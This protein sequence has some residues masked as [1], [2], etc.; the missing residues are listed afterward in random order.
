MKRRVLFLGIGI[1]WMMTL[2]GI[3]LYP[4]DYRVVSSQFHAVNPEEKPGAP[5]G[6]GPNELIVY[7]PDYGQRTGTNMWGVEAI[8]RNGII[9]HI[10]GNNSPI[11]DD[12]KVISGHGQSR[13]WILDGL[14]I[15]MEVEV[16]YDEK[17]ITGS[18]TDRS[19][20]YLLEKEYDLYDERSY[21]ALFHHS[22]QLER[23]LE[24]VRERLDSLHSQVTEEEVFNIRLYRRIKSDLEWIYWEQFPYLEE[25]RGLFLSASLVINHSEDILKFADKHSFRALYI[26]LIEDKGSVIRNNALYPDAPYS[27]SLDEW[28]EIL[29]ILNENDID[30]YFVFSPLKL[31]PS[32]ER[33]IQ[34]NQD[35][36]VASQLSRNYFEGEASYYL[37]PLNAENQRSILQFIR[38]LKNDLSPQGLVLRD[39]YLPVEREYD[40]CYCESC[41]QQFFSLTG[42]DPNYF[43]FLG[44]DELSKKWLNWRQD[45]LSDFLKEILDIFEAGLFLSFPD[46]YMPVYTPHQWLDDRLTEYAIFDRTILKSGIFPRY[47]RFMHNHPLTA[48]YMV[49]YNERSPKRMAETILE[50]YTLG[51]TSPDVLLIQGLEDVIILEEDTFST[52]RQKRRVK[53]DTL[54]KIFR[55]VETRRFWEFWKLW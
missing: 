12:G 25:K 1:S 3:G 2:L 6:R 30:V 54:H 46:S 18:F 40:S 36:L 51:R 23:R 37:C 17:V 52:R 35:L 7:L 31:H 34:N 13:L 50:Y 8:V 21:D 39:Y 45:S 19:R 11:P 28:Q 15:G 53:R 33:Y 27:L 14:H 10:G 16:D 20:V 44:S 49:D 32:W 43:D 5:A 42:V 47:R 38:I 22:E 29:N 9:E 55:E 48:K 4:V 24:R 41:S 26:P